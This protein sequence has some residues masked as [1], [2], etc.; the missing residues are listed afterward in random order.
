MEDD[1]ASNK[2]N[3][4]MMDIALHLVVST[5]E[6]L[7]TSPDRLTFMWQLKSECSSGHL[8]FPQVWNTGIILWFHM[9]KPWQHTSFIL[10][11]YCH[12]T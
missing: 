2:M 11:R 4:P 6:H 10:L 8:I 7:D 9:I 3:N 5:S 1:T 12:L